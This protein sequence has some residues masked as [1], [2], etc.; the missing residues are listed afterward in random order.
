MT[1]T[2]RIDNYLE[3][4][5]VT[6]PYLPKFARYVVS[7]GFYSK[8][9]WVNGVN[10]LKLDVI[11]KLRCDADLRY[12]YTGVQ[13]PLGRHRK[14]D[15]K[16]DLT[17]VSRMSLVRELEPNLF[18]YDVVVW[19]LSL[20]RKVRLA[21]LRDCRDPKRVGRV[22]LFS[23]DI[24][25]GASDILDFYTARFQIEFIFRDAKQFTGLSDCQARDFTKLDFH[26]NASLM[27]LNLA[28]FEAIQ[29]HQSPKPFVFS[30]ASFKWLALNRYLLERFIS[31]L[32]LDSTLIKS[33]PNFPVLC[34]Y[35]AIA[36]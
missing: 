11:S 32:D 9:K 29:L 14:Y 25:L 26:F 27:T 30:M 13:K 4:L 35:G 7:D 12:V 34:S 24:H 6:Y 16:V 2:T 23:T 21:F 5:Q 3:H 18:L 20:K 8:I 17:D 15:G 19:S 1:E 36:Y 10:A 22:L 31:L 28:K 33:H